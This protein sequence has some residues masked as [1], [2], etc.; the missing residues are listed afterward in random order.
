MKRETRADA[1]PKVIF[2]DLGGVLVNVHL[3]RFIEGLARHTGRSRAELI[4][5]RESMRPDSRLFDSGGI[6]GDEFLERLN[7]KLGRPLARPVLAK[8]YTEIFS[9]KEDVAGLARSL[10][11]RFRLSI[12]SNT[13]PLHYDYIIG[14]YPFFNLFEK[15][16][17]SFAAGLLKPDQAIYDFALREL[18]VDADEALFVDDLQENVEGA[19]KAGIRALHFTGAAALRIQLDGLLP[20]EG[21]R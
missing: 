6:A 7:R 10:N 14:R 1:P 16:V 21:A 4:A 3:E 8:L 15:P 5:L 20:P 19:R 2:F 18:A 17:T 9:L 12:I 11:G 13:D